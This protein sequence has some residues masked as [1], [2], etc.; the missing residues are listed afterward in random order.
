MRWVL[1]LLSVVTVNC[2]EALPA[3][4]FI[5]RH[6]EKPSHGNDLDTRGRERAAALAPYFLNAKELQ[7]YGLPVAIYAQ[8]PSS[9]DPSLRP[10]Q[11]ATPIAEALGLKVDT[12]FDHKHFSRLAQEIRTRPEYDGKTVLIAW[13][14]HAIP[15]LARKLG[16][17]NVP[18]KWDGDVFDRVWIITYSGKQVAFQDIPQRLL[19]GDSP[20]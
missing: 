9:E 10:I 3:Q 8:R 2:A 11:T 4:V 6:A 13:E 7:R 20:R 5:I 19:F 14:H 16:A 17:R 18:K 12:T 15:E 1:L